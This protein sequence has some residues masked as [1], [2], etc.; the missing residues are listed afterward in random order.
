LLAHLKVAGDKSSKAWKESLK[1]EKP[2]AKCIRAWAYRREIGPT[3][4]ALAVLGWPTKG[5]DLETGSVKLS[6][7]EAL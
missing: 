2:F 4:T 1:E 7:H 5:P 3:K 6:K